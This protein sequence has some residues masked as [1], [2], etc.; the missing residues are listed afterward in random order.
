VQANLEMKRGELKKI[1]NE[2][3]NE[4]LCELNGYW[5]NK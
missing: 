3:E 1:R 4:K 5:P 2:K